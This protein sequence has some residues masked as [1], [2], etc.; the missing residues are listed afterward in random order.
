MRREEA[1]G[2]F[3]RP[4]TAGLATFRAALERAGVACTVRRSPGVDIDAACGQL[5]LRRDARTPAG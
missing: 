2:E 5:A 1:G 4:T 3:R